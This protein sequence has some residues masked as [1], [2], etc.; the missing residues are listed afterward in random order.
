MFMAIFHDFHRASLPGIKSAFELISRLAVWYDMRR[1]IKKLTNEYQA[2]ARSKIIR[3][4]LAR[5]EAVTP[6]LRQRFAHIF[7]DLIVPLGKS[8]NHN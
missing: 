5:V 2:C 4:K 6:S 7:V 1:D 8:K 3:H